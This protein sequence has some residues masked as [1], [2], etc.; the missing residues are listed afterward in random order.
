MFSRINLGLYF[1]QILFFGYETLDGVIANQ[2]FPAVLLLSLLAPSLFL[3][4]TAGA[5]YQKLVTSKSLALSL[6]DEEWSHSHCFCLPFLALSIYRCLE[7]FYSFRSDRRSTR[8]RY[9]RCCIGVSL[10]VSSP[11]DR[12][13]PA[14]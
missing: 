6:P 10:H 1:A 11:F 2:S 12:I 13:A 14:F 9:G 7:A 8:L 4:A 5:A 3:G